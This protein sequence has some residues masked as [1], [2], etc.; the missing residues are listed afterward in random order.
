[1]EKT[2]MQRQSEIGT[3][4]TAKAF[5][6]AFIGT[7]LTAM[8]FGMAWPYRIDQFASPGIG[9]R[10]GYWYYNVTG[11]LP[12]LGM[13]L[14]I[15]M[16]IALVNGRGG[17]RF[18]RQE[19]ALIAIMIPLS[20]LY[21][22][23][24]YTPF[25]EWFSEA[26][27][28]AKQ[29]P[30]QQQM[31]WDR[32]PDG[33][34]GP[35]EGSF[36]VFA[37]GT[38]GASESPRTLVVPWG[39][40]IPMMATAIFFTLGGML[41]LTF[42]SLLLRRLYVR[43][44]Y[45]A[46]PTAEI[47]SGFVDLT[48]PG[49][50]KPKIFKSKP[51][52]VVFLV[53]FLYTFPLWGLKYWATLATGSPVDWQPGYIPGTQIYLW[54]AVDL[55][56]YA[57]LPWVPLLVTLAPWEIGWAL[58]LPTNVQL[59]TVIGYLAMFVFV[60]LIYNSVTGAWGEFPEGLSVINVT[61]RGNFRSSTE[62][63]SWIAIQ[64]GVAAAL[65][66][67]PLIM[68]WRE[69]SPIFKAI[70][71]EPDPSYDPDRPISYRLT[72][73][74]TIGT[75]LLWYLMGTVVLGMDW[76]A[77]LIFD[78][79]MAV[80]FL[81]QARIIAETGGFYGMLEN[82]QYFADGGLVGPAAMQWAGILP[83][84]DPAP[85]R[86]YITYWHMNTRT[87]TYSWGQRIPWYSLHSMKISD[88]TR[89]RSRDAL[90]ILV[91]GIALSLTSLA[92]VQIFNRAYDTIITSTRGELANRS[93]TSVARGSLG[94]NTNCFINADKTL[95]QIAIGFAMI[96]ILALVQTRVSFLRP[97]SLGGIA[98]GSYVGWNV[99]APFLAAFI[100]KYIVLHTKGIA[101][102]ESVVK[103]AALGLLAGALLSMA[104]AGI[105]NYAVFL[106]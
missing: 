36:W 11:F 94:W 20:S 19:V 95:I 67:V 101:L 89:T 103:P 100:I 81:G 92:V 31:Y 33:I 73:L 71:K 14:L 25:R 44:E 55:T 58:I 106:S 57:L 24:Y 49:S 26:M 70:V 52:L 27:W 90:L 76:L 88:Q 29:A 7:V 83:S 63:F 93:P 9:P 41:C 97:L 43:T 56:Q 98:L 21:V 35:E 75:G 51:F 17:I 46:M 79:L 104:L 34:F 54:P 85:L 59:S 39:P 66:V 50:E 30:D 86:A 62:G 23:D 77:L 99:W 13:A 80:L 96:F 47:V 18:S 91:L 5:V 40:L 60:P 3:G 4:L 69:V 16:V 12:G 82:V 15:L 22:G 10:S 37:I 8:L 53:S 1:M 105:G 48:Q 84:E 74:L 65:L 102:Y 61:F 6:V 38:A 64:V 78:V 28:V 45:L 68:N 32:L 42:A 87:T 2:T 72:W